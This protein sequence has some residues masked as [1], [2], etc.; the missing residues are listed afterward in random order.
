MRRRRIGQVPYGHAVGPP[1]PLTAFDMLRGWRRSSLSD[2]RDMSRLTS[3]EFVGRTAELARL[4]DVWVRARG[5]ATQLV[6]ISGEA[7]I[8]KTRLIAEFIDRISPDGAEAAI[9]RCLDVGPGTL[10]YEPFAE[11]LRSLLAPRSA[12]DRDRLA[13]PFG[14]QLSLLVPDLFD[15]APEPRPHGERLGTARLFRSVAAVLE[16]IATEAPLCLAIEDIHWIDSA[17]RDLLRYLSGSVTRSPILILATIRTDELPLGHAV[18]RTLGE[19]LRLQDRERVDLARLD[20]GAVEGQVRG[21]IGR[22]PDPSLVDLVYERSDGNPFF[23]EEVVAL[24]LDS[25]GAAGLSPSLRDMLL[26]R[27]AAASDDVQTLLRAGAVAGRWIDDRALRSVTGLSARRFQVAMHDA[28]RRHFLIADDDRHGPGYAFRNA[29]VRDAILEDL[30]ASERRAWHLTWA[31]VLDGLAAPP[32][33]LA[34]HWH[35]A[36]RSD[37]AAP[38]FVRAAEE[39]AAAYA[40][41]T[42][43]GHYREALA[44]LDRSPATLGPPLDRLEL[45][46]R[47]ALEHEAA[48]ERDE[49]IEG[50]QAVLADTALAADP[51]RSIRLRRR[52]SEIAQMRARRPIAERAIAEALSMIGEDPDAEGA[53]VLATHAMQQCLNGELDSARATAARAVE[54]ARRHG[55]LGVEARALRV[56]AELRAMVDAD[57][58][59]AELRAAAALAEAAGDFGYAYQTLSDIPWALANAS[60]WAEALRATDDIVADAVRAGVGGELLRTHIA[61]RIE[62]LTALGRWTEADAEVAA[63]GPARAW[64]ARLRAVIL[65]SREGRIDDAKRLLTETFELVPVTATTIPDRGA[66]ALARVDLALAL[67]DPVAAVD[68]VDEAG[69]LAGEADMESE[70]RLLGIRACGLGADGTARPSERDAWA[71]RAK[72]H[73]ERL[74]ALGEAD[75]GQAGPA[76]AV[77]ILDGRAEV[78][79]IEGRRDVAE[80]SRVADAWARLDVPERVS[81]A[82]YREA[83]AIVLRRGR[84][85]EAA[86][87]LREAHRIASGLGAAPLVAAI[88]ALAVRARIALAPASVETDVRPVAASAVPADPHGLSERE[89]EVLALLAVGRTNREIG[90][91]LFI[92]PKTAGVH[93]SNILGK[94]GAVNRVEAASIAHRLQ[95]LGLPLPDPSSE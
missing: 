9:G 57:A 62:Y 95:L 15:E 36:G 85:A 55:A 50:L 32:A 12:P 53:A 17:S 56:L 21:I 83:E 4:E 87:P 47:A 37:L 70:L 43:A 8:G 11:I 1:I 14:A 79:R 94:L 86:S 49:A 67:G 51:A 34:A 13:G 89:R 66:I 2:G 7:G 78:S 23:T 93:V 84:A 20:R 27:L 19:I 33:T 88:E 42:A 64:M 18:H 61:R 80:W 28:A 48:G 26:A 35:G 68:L 30:L 71:G 46:E 63:T 38:L 90:A 39:A 25:D 69:P 74:V 6:L 60:R 91:A 5:S 54:I 65:R 77:R 59:I 10:P 16:G 44:M 52:L 45:L 92:S 40:H 73:L 24:E 76:R 3:P 82:R 29:L 72:G 58:G 81:Q 41:A 22:Q 75:G 31:G